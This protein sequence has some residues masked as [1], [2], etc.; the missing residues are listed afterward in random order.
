MSISPVS[1]ASLS[2]GVL[3]SGNSTQLTQALQAL[4]NSLS[5]G[6]LAGAQSGFQSLLRLN[7]ALAA[8]S[9]SASSSDT[10]LSSDLTTLG[11]AI[12]SADLSGAQSAFTTVQ[13]DLKSVSSS[14]SLAVE[15]NAVTQSEQLV[16]DLLSPLNTFSLSDNTSSLLQSVYATPSLNVLA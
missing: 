12:S 8:A 9:G 7:T 14:P 1:A 3:A 15:A 4:E 5:A 2:E 11:S 13:N 6:D 10:Q 16:A